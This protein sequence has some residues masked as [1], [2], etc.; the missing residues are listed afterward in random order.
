MEYTKEAKEE[1]VRQMLEAIGENPD[2]DGLLGTPERVVRMW[3][4]VFGG[5]NE[6][7]KPKITSFD[8]GKDGILNDE[9]ICDSGTFYSHCE[10]HAIPFF[11]KYYFAYIPHPKGKILGLSK[12]GRVV[13]YYSHKLQIQERLG[14]DIIMCL[15]DALT[16]EMPNDIGDKPGIKEMFE[17]LGM[18]IVMEGEHLCKTM[19]GVKKKGKMRTTKLMGV[20][21]T[22]PAT[23]AEFMDWVNKNEQ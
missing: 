19:R 3:E 5:Y 1:I 10:H 16:K 11:G 7:N 15:W 17:P 9:M 12:V 6:A 18:A 22:D 8:N 20:F 13:D 21:K 2:R 23:R 14:Y 4:E